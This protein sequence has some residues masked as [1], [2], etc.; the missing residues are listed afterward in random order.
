M[1]ISKQYGKEK[2]L[3]TYSEVGNKFLLNEVSEGCDLPFPRFK[4]L[5]NRKIIYSSMDRTE[6][7]KFFCSVV[8]DR[9]MQLPL[10]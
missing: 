5:E 3:R 7:D 1:R 4:V 6:C 9:I 10:C 2:T 8:Y